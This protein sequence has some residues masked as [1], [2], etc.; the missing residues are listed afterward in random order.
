MWL[1]FWP[2]HRIRFVVLVPRNNH[3][4]VDDARNASEEPQENI[5]DD[6]IRRTTYEDSNRRENQRKKIEKKGAHKAT[7]NVLRT[8]SGSFMSIQQSV[9]ATTCRDVPLN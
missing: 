5:Q 9:T 6:L 2:R 1:S 7:V 8:S 4:S 3:K